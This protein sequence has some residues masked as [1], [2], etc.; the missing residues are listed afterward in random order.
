MVVNLVSSG[1]VSIQVPLNVAIRMKVVKNLIEDMSFQEQVS[2]PLPCI[3]TTC[4]LRIVEW[5]KDNP[6]P[7]NDDEYDT[8]LLSEMTCKEMRQMINTCDYLDIEDAMYVYWKV[9]SDKLLE[10]ETILYRDATED[11]YANIPALLRAFAFGDDSQKDG[12]TVTT[13]CD[14]LKCYLSRRI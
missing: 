14:V 12:A 4:L 9:F 5:I 11:D 8:S 1:G 13:L 3:D 2:I 6:M 7:V 10:Y